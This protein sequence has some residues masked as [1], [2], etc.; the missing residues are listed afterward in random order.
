[1]GKGEVRIQEERSHREAQRCHQQVIQEERIAGAGQ[2]YVQPVL[3]HPMQMQ[4]CGNLYSP[5]L[6][7]RHGG[8]MPLLWHV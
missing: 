8:G 2:R 7:R 4:D 1:M 3:Q 5:S 6:Q